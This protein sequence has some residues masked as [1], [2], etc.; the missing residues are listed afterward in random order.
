[1][2]KGDTSTSQMVGT[3]EHE[4]FF[5][6]L[7]PTPA[8]ER[9]ALGMVL[10]MFGAFFIVEVYL[11]SLRLPR[12][13]AFV[14]AYGVAMFVNDSITAALLFAQFAILRSRA[15]LAISCGYLFTALMPIPWLLTFPGAFAPGGLVVGLQSTAALYFFWHAG[16]PAFVIAYAFL[17]NTDPSGRVR[18]AS[19]RGAIVAGL[20]VTATLVCA[21]TILVTAG[22]DLLPRVMDDRTR[23]GTRWIYE[24]AVASLMSVVAVVVLW[25][26][27]R[28]LLDLY[29]IV[30]MCGFVIEIALGTFPVAARFTVGWYTGR[31]FGVLSGSIIL[32][33]LLYESTTLYAQ[34]LRAH[35][36]LRRER[37]ERIM[38]ADAVSA[39][40]AHEINQPLSAMITN[41]DAGLLWIASPAPDLR[42]AGAA[43]TR[44]IADGHR[45]AAV[46]NGIRAMLR[47][48]VAHRALLDMNELIC[49]A[50]A[51]LR[52]EL[53]SYRVS[54]RAEPKDG[55]PRVKGDHVQL[56][57][58]LV[59]LI[60]N[61]I[62]SMAAVAGERSLCVRSRTDESGGVTVQVADTGRGL[63]PTNID[64]IFD[65]MF[66]TKPHGMGMG[67][68]ICRAIVEAH[69]G[70][71]SAAPNGAHG[72]VF[73]FTLPARSSA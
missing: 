25:A 30:V 65:P 56:Q 40:I 49:E 61:A 59:N 19:V 15:L 16:F 63:E 7:P 5:S 13:D 38:T 44:I 8:Q 64:R 27:R 41:A 36:A 58:V 18:H 68:S 57:Q 47:K 33:V 66:T 3:A 12:V 22:H 53:Q 51:L 52:S 2:S 39:S 55:L 24:G 9:L 21:L 28:S 20:T 71:L 29:L 37:N 11:S 45:A 54:V 67:L 4:F 73:Q 32:F 46:I 1:M 26:R 70:R 14:P 23:F 62:E 60:M 69:E 6:S 43:F 31:I 50:L 34:L 17:K 35:M 72:A 10:V 42:E 48:D